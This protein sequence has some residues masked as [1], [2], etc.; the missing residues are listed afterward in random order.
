MLNVLLQNSQ[1]QILYE[2]EQVLPNGARRARG[3]PLS[4]KLLPG[5]VRTAECLGCATLHA[6]S[7][8]AVAPLPCCS[9]LPAPRTTC[10]LCCL[11]L[12]CFP[13]HVARPPP[14]RPPFPLHLLGRHPTLQRWQDAVVR[15]VIEELGPVLPADPKVWGDASV[16]Q[17]ASPPPP[18]PRPALWVG[19][20]R[21]QERHAC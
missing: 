15:G 3:L 9:L 1:G 11:W 12:P 4:E 16:Q 18:L 13:C 6:C 19:G 5:E 10:L 2:D 20:W 14:H 8:L 21:R 17:R 7:L